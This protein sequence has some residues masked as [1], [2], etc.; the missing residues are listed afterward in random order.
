[1]AVAILE[2][3]MNNFDLTFQLNVLA[4]VAPQ[5]SRGRL[6]VAVVGALAVVG[7]HECASEQHKAGEN[8]TAEDP[9]GSTDLDLHGG[10]FLTA[11]IA[12]W[13]EQSEIT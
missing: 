7:E 1:V 11:M 10:T 5:L 2:I 6:G 12:S 4:R 8:R 13:I 9:R 3:L